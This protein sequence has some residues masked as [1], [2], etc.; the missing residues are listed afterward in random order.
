[1]ST[2]WTERVITESCPNPPRPNGK[3]AT[4]R[5]ASPV[6]P[7]LL[8]NSHT[9]NGIPNIGEPPGRHAEHAPTEASFLQRYAQKLIAA[10]T[11]LQSVDTIEHCHDVGVRN[12]EIFQTTEVVEVLGRA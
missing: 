6:P 1:M 3:R 7:I 4:R 8:Q 12:I 5:N 9:Q 2:A 11:C 10:A